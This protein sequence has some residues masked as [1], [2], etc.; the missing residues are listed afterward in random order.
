MHILREGEATCGCGHIEIKLAFTVTSSQ[1]D[2]RKVKQE[3]TDV[4]AVSCRVG[5]RCPTSELKVQWG[6]LIKF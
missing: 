6:Q 5:I 4:L 2:D 3:K 1:C